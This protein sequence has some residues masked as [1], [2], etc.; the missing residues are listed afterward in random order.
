MIIVIDAINKHRFQHILDDMFRLRA[1]VFADRLGWEVDVRDGKEIDKF[2]RLDP[3]YIVGLDDEGH[4]VACVRALQTTGPHMLADVFSDILD[5]EPP[6]RS[7]TL[8]ESTRFCVDTQRLGRGKARNSISYATCELMIGALEYARNSGISDIVTVIDPVIDRILKRSDTAP[9]DYVGTAK[10]MGKAKAMAALLD[11][12][13]ERIDRIRAF[14]GIH[15]DVHLTEEE[16]LALVARRVTAEAGTT[17][18]GVVEGGARANVPAPTRADI[19]DYV[20]AQ[21]SAARDAE[22]LEAALSLMELLMKSGGAER[23]DE[24]VAHRVVG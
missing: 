11:C 6:L 14:A 24:S 13:P 5:G 9:Y 21:I 2:D 17:P 23:T 1:R 4:V 15:H 19:Q 7:A 22:E 3:A 10:Q 18:L 12:T 20:R 16:A 8:W